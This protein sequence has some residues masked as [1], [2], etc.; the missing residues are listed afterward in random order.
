MTKNRPIQI[1]IVLAVISIVG[2]I[3]VQ[4]FWVS[5]AIN[6]EEENFDHNVRMALRSVADQ[7]CQIDGNELIADKPIDR[8]SRGYFI[9]RLRY[10]IDVSQLENLITTQFDRRGIEQDYEYAVYDCDTDQMVFGSE[11]ISG[12]HTEDLTIPD[13]VEDEYYFGVYFPNKTGGLLSEMNV[14]KFMTVA[15][16]LMIGFF[17]YGLVI[18]LRQRRLSEVQKDFIDNVTHELKT[19]LATLRLASDAISQKANQ[20]VD[21]YADIISS[22]V[23]RL[24]EQVNQILSVSV[25]EKSNQSKAVP[26]SVDEQI[27]SI[28]DQ[29]AIAHPDIVWQLQLDELPQITIIPDSIQVICKNLM[30][31]ALKYGRGEVSVIAKHTEHEMTITVSDNGPGIPKGAEKKIFDKFYRVP[32]ND[33]HDVK[34]YGLGMYLVKLHLKKMKGR[35]RY[36]RA[37][38]RSHFEIK[39]PVK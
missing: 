26:T 24:E 37:N 16:L 3:A 10:H 29:L 18:V 21:S 34:G 22:E 36:Y 23:D 38:D 19:P 7:M 9:A 13:L 17:S 25:D 32:T 33:V 12:T 6:E 39:L 11:V 30:D 4:I 20:A 8:V 14:W 5:Q 28:Y 2:I 27:R 1:M 15:T 31:N 35:I